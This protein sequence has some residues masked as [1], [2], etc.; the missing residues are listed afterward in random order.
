MSDLLHNF[1]VNTKKI[2]NPACRKPVVVGITTLCLDHQAVLGNTL[3]EIAIQKAGIMKENVPAYTVA[4]HPPHI[5][6]L[7]QARAREVKVGRLL[8]NFNLLIML[9]FFIFLKCC[10]YKIFL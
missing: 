1:F 6:D 10:L 8:K 4:T 7:L 9:N 3:E 2:K 5:Y